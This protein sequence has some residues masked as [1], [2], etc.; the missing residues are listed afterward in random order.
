MWV[1]NFYVH[2]VQLNGCTEY[3]T[4]GSD[5]PVSFFIADVSICISK[6]DNTNI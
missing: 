1:F 6:N 3:Q 4:T 5:D 2:M